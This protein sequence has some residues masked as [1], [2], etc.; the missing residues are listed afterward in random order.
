MNAFNVLRSIYPIFPYSQWKYQHWALVLLVQLIR[1]DEPTSP[2]KARI[3]VQYIVSDHPS[4][5]HAAQR[6]AGLRN[7]R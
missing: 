1:R 4:M 5:R 2:E 6:Y 3:F 7:I